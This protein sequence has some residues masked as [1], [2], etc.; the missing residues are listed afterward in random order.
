M[1]ELVP[2]IVPVPLAVLTDDPDLGLRQVAGPEQPET[3]VMLCTPVRWPTRCR[4]SSAE[5]CC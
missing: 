3:L 5:S 2:P 4:I 1:Q